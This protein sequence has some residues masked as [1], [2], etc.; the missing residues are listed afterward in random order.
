MGKGSMRYLET[1]RS[2]LAVDDFPPQCPRCSRFIS[3]IFT[4]ALSEKGEDYEEAVFKCPNCLNFFIGVYTKRYGFDV[5]NF[6]ASLPNTPVSVEFP[7]IDLISDRFSEIYNQTV[8]AEAYGLIDIAGTGYRK[9]LEFIVKDYCIAMNPEDGG[10]IRKKFLK[11]VIDDHI[12]NGKLKRAATLTVWLGNDEGHYERRWVDKDL[13][14]LKALLSLTIA[15]VQEEIQMEQ[16]VR[17]MQP[18][19]PIRINLREAPK[20]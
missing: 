10:Q 9:A 6:R 19:T 20:T 17:S 15:F 8:A 16:Y 14:D 2:K 1:S 18:D 4:G 11:N 7:L 12:D 5:Y 3:A 13:T